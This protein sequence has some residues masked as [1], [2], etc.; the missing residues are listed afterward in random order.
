M[1]KTKKPKLQELKQVHAKQE[2]FQPTMLDQ[3]WGGFSNPNAQFGTTDEV[4][5]TTRLRDMTR[6]DLE[7]HARGVGVI[8]VEDNNR[9]KESLLRAFRGYIASIR[10]PANPR[11]PQ[12]V[13]EEY[14]R[15]MSDAK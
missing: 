11:V 12:K 1:P 2:T 13:T 5:Y 14:S 8:V 9:L 6:V 7:N 15:L 3:V 4:E 10:K